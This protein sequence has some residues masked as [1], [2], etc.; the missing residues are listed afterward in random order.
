MRTRKTKV[1]V[2]THQLLV[3][4]DGKRLREDWCR[5]CSKLVRMLSADEAAAL[6]GVSLRTLCHRVET[7]KL[8]FK[9]TGDGLLFICLDSLLQ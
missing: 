2:E 7:G 8:H 4:R 1:T 6:A 3:I 5:S 9:E